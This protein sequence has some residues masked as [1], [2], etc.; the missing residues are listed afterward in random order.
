MNPPV[1]ETCKASSA[2]TALLG[3]NPTRLYQF[4]VAPQNASMPYAV[5]QVVGGSPANLINQTP[6]IDSY[7]VQIDVY[8]NDAKTAR[9]AALALRGAI[10]KTAN[11]VF[12]G[13]ENIDPET[14]AFREMFR[15][16]W[17]VH[18]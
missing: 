7:T 3:T 12:Y 15:V 4:G 18:R 16:D 2:V 9:S 14:G 10:E 17:F 5:W 1:F 8:A 13:G 11:V 6:D